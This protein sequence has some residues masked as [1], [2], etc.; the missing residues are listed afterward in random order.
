MGDESWNVHY[1]DYK[2]TGLVNG[3]NYWFGVAAVNSAGQ[4]PISGPVQVVPLGGPRNVTSSVICANT[5]DPIPVNISW[6]PPSDTTG[7]SLYLVWSSR[8]GEHVV[9]RNSSWFNETVAC[10]WGNQY[11]VTTVYQDG[12]RVYSDYV[13]VAG[14]MVEGDPNAGSKA[15]T[16]IGTIILLSNVIGGAV[17][18]TQK[19]LRIRG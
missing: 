12:S 3:L 1:Y 8:T 14:P 13:Y 9:D 2:I 18:L 15:L 10:D 6:T 19:R 11:R 5:A 7:I 16:L 4:G 17:I